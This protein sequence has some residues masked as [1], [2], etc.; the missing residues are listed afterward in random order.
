MAKALWEAVVDFMRRQA[1]R[2]DQSHE[3]AR[4]RALLHDLYLLG[5]RPTATEIC[6]RA[7][8][9]GSP[10]PW[11][12]YVAGLWTDRLRSPDRHVRNEQRWHNPFVI[13]DAQARAHEL[14]DVSARLSRRVS[15]EAENLARALEEGADQERVVASRNA[16]RRQI[17]ALCIWAEVL[18]ELL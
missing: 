18:I 11:S 17:F 15:V 4:I 5:E 2:S 10:T 13:A 8:I 14:E 7:G 3:A 6:A 16:L 9:N 12:R 1:S